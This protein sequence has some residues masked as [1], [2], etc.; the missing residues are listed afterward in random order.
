MLW[1]VM[2]LR[3][4]S[5]THVQELR[6]RRVAPQHIDAALAVVFGDS[7]QLAASGGPSDESQE[8]V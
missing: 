5:C 2:L 6:M 7:K 4:L 1:C 3:L 8:G